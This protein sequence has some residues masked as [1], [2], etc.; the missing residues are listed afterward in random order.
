VSDE[1]QSCDLCQLPVEAPGFELLTTAGR[2]RF[3]CEGCQGIYRMLHE[4][5]LVG[6]GTA[7]VD[8]D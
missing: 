6:D 8:P 3:C 4:D 1:I 7:P 5:E 2:K